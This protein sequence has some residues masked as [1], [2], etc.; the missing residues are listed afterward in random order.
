MKQDEYPDEQ[1]LGAFVDG[2]LDAAVSESVLESMEHNEQVREQVYRLRRSKDLIKLAFGDAQAPS[3]LPAPAVVRQPLWPSL[4]ASVLLLVGSFGTGVLG[5]F[6]GKQLMG[7]DSEL[8]ARQHRNHVVLHIS[9][10]DPKQ[11]S[12]ALDYVENFLKQHNNPGSQVEVVAN[13]GGL[14]FMRVGISPFEDRVSAMI[15]KYKNVHFIACANGI[16]NLR[17]QGE[18]PHFIDR[19]DTGKTAIDHIISRL[20]A[21]WSYIKVDALPEV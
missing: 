8:V 21:G 4:A 13:A 9:E 12:A 18:D 7:S 16:R 5:Y 20:Q 15:R 6:C 3:R 14:D 10:S 11:F 19:I 2:Q 1:T 17:R